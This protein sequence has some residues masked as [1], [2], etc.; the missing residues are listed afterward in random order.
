MGE[1]LD[2]TFYFTIDFFKIKVKFA[3]VT[4][5]DLINMK[6]LCEGHFE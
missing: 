3:K 4:R 2:T 6:T 5:P 1:G